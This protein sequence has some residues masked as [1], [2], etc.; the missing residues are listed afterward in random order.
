M[1]EIKSRETSSTIPL[2]YTSRFSIMRVYMEKM[3]V[4]GAC[5]LILLLLPFYSAASDLVVEIEHF[6]APDQEN[7]TVY[8]KYSG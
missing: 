7:P 8:S 5:I 1:L 3:S 6:F 2:S 4:Y